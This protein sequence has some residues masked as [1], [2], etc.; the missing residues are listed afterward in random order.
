MAQF[1]ILEKFRKLLKKEENPADL[2]VD[3]A[4]FVNSAYNLVL[5]RDTDAAALELYTT[6]L[7]KGEL[8][9]EQVFEILL[10]SDEYI[11]TQA[12]KEEPIF[13]YEFDRDEQFKHFRSKQITSL[14]EA[15][16]KH[17][18]FT[19]ADM[20]RAVPGLAELEYYVLHKKRFL[21]M[22][23]G[24]A[25]IEQTL[26]TP[27]NILEIGSIF[28]TKFIKTLFPHARIS[29]IDVID[30]DNIGYRGVY[31]L[32]EIVEQ[33]YK[34]DLV[35]ENIADIDLRP[36]EKFD[37]VLLCE[38]IEHL[39]INPIK[40]MKFLLSQMNSGGYMYL[41]TPNA[42][43]RASIECLKRLVI[44]YP[45]YPEHYSYA[46][47]HMFHVR[48]YGMA[49]LLNF[50]REA[51]GVVRAFYFS[52]CWDDPQSAAAMPPHELSNLVILIQKP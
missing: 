33:H 3:H 10:R 51:G 15:L 20:D 24:L 37:I 28:S 52:D 40:L 41:T 17:A 49:E 25:F 8:R 46:D 26:A 42:L 34:I 5:N 36:H 47:A 19:I 22:M 31:M 12:P 1:N 44:P 29:T 2:D 6:L 14:S 32:D 48:E 23:N 9:R 30:A 16:S 11:S 45:V 39:L 21:E 4:R 35:R 18:S 13:V 43:K 38:V 7:E 27:L 50:A